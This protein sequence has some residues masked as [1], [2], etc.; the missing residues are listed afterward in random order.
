M[1]TQRAAAVQAVE[2]GTV[3]FAGTLRGLDQAVLIDHGSYTSVT[4]RLG[5]IRVTVGQSVDPGQ[6]LGEAAGDRV[7]LEIRLEVGPGGEPIDPAPLLA[8]P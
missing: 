4:G 8:R 6:A 2:A 7:Y 3:R 5:R 1:R